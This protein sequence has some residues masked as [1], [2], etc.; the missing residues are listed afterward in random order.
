MTG[1]AL[2]GFDIMR[3]LYS[4]QTH[5]GV[6][7]KLSLLLLGLVVLVNMGC[8]SGSPG[9]SDGVI[10]NEIVLPTD[11]VLNLACIDVGVYLEK[12]I[13]ED[14]AN[15]YRFVAT[16]EFVEDEPDADI[17]KFLLSEQIP[18]GPTGAKARFYLWATALARRASGENQYYTARALHEVWTEQV[19]AG[20]GDPII[21]DQAKRAYRAV[22]DYFFGAVVFFEADFFVPPLVPDLKYSFIIS[23]LVGQNLYD[24]AVF[25]P[26]WPD[27][28]STDPVATSFR[29][30]EAM[31]AWGFTYDHDNKIVFVNM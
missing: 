3:N 27:P 10:I 23:D 17:G 31:S 15:P 30:K 14:E 12:C 21:Q 1:H 25:D 26:L 5:S 19:G 8:K 28:I 29:A 16:G 11:L 20:F 13:L 22:L 4:K 7:K 9:S 24:D 18:A 2:P 6:F